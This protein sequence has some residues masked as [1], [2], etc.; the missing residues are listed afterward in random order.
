MRHVI[1]AAFF[2][3][4]ALVSGPG[5]AQTQPESGIVK[6]NSQNLLQG[7]STWSRQQRK[8]NVP[9]AETNPTMRQPSP[10]PAQP[11]APIKPVPITPPARPNI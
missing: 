7:P 9:G 11:R 6:P 5:E 3:G 4:I 10:A 2:A 1:G 8:L